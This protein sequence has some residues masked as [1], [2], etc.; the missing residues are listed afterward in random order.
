MKYSDRFLPDYGFWKAWIEESSFPLKKDIFLLALKSVARSNLVLQFLDHMSKL[1]EDNIVVS[2][3]D[4]L[5]LS[6][7]LTLFC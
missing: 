2:L 1:M 5:T 7:C 4:L 6:K 3:K